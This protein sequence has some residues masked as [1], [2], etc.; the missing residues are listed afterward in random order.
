MNIKYQELANGHAY[1]LDNTC[2][3]FPFGLNPRMVVNTIAG[4]MTTNIDNPERFGTWDT[5]QS[6]REY[7]QNF[8]N[9]KS[10]ATA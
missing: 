3:I 1:T 9:S 7:I 10:E 8:V 2:I 6:R 5:T 4:L